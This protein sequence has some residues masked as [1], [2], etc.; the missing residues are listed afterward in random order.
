MNRVR[1][2]KVELDKLS[3]NTNVVSIVEPE[4]GYEIAPE[5]QQEESSFITNNYF[6]KIF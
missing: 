1:A 5:I 4:I 6:S 3:K 2:N